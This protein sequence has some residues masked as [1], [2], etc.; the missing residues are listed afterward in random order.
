MPLMTVCPGYSRFFV[1][2]GA[3]AYHN[4]KAGKCERWRERDAAKVGLT[5]GFTEKFLKINGFS[6]ETRFFKSPE[7][8]CLAWIYIH[9]FGFAWNGEGLRL[10]PPQTMTARQGRRFSRLRF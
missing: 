10:T 9:F 6:Y 5:P 1:H 3:V 2:G 8:P 7:K 4:K